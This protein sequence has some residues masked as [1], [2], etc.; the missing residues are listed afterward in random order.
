[1]WTGALPQGAP[2]E[3]FLG[4]QRLPCRALALVQGGLWGPSPIISTPFSAIVLSLL[5]GVEVR[6]ELRLKMLLLQGWHVET[7]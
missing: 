1:M 7:Q 4:S 3:S 6:Q 5:R 2:S